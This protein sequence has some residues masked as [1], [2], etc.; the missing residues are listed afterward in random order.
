MPTLPV[1][2][3]IYRWHEHSKYLTARGQ[4][5]IKASQSQLPGPIIPA[6]RRLLYQFK[7]VARHLFTQ[8]KQN[9]AMQSKPSASQSNYPEGRPTPHPGNRRGCDDMGAVPI[10]PSSPSG[11]C[12]SF[13]QAAR[14]EKAFLPGA[15]PAPLSCVWP[16]DPPYQRERTDLSSK[17]KFPC[18]FQKLKKPENTPQAPLYRC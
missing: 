14:S 3:F 2:T 5:V 7:V 9:S 10:H 12:S 17:L 15:I 13:R 4:N 8:N 1:T 18:I 11:F 6:F 16:R